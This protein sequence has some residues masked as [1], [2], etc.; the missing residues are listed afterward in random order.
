MKK[1][2]IT[3]VG[4]MFCAGLMISNAAGKKEL[5]AEQQKQKKDLIE[6]YDTD[7]NGK[8]SKQEREKMTDADKEAWAKLQGGGNKKAK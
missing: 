6:K 4:I 3:I 5:N 1:V 8:L 2:L 7:K